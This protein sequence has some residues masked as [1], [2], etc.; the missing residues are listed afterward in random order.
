MQ[1]KFHNKIS[2]NMAMLPGP[3]LNHKITTAV[4][5]NRFDKFLLIFDIEK[6][7]LNIKLYECDQNRLCFLWFRNILKGDFTI[8]GYKNLRL[9][10]GLRPSPAILMLGLYKILILD[11]SGEE[12]LDNMKKAIYNGIYMDNGSYSCNKEEDLMEAFQ[13]LDGIFGPHKLA[14]QQFGTN[15]VELQRVVDERFEETTPSSVKFFGMMWNRTEDTLSPQ[16]INLQLKAMTKRTILSTLNSIYD[17]YNVYAPILLR[18]K[19][20]M[21]ILQTRTDLGWDTVIPDELQEEWKRIV[22]QAN[23]SP[24]I[25]LPR[26][27]GARGSKYSLVAFTDASKDAYGVVV[28]IK[29]MYSGVVSYLTAKN[30]IVNSGSL[31]RTIP[32]LELQGVCFGAETLRELKDSL[33][34]TSVVSP[35]EISSLVL[36]SDSTVCLHWLRS[37]SVFFEKMQKVTIFVKNRLRDIDNVCN[38]YPITFHHIGGDDN[39]ADRLTRPSSYKI[40]SRTNYFVGP[41]LLRNDLDVV[42]NDLSFILPNATC[43]KADEVPDH[44]GCVAMPVS[45]S[46]DETQGEVPQP[47]QLV[48]LDKYSS[49]KFLVGVTANIIKFVNNIRKK[50]SIKRNTSLRLL[51]NEEIHYSAV[52]RIISIEQQRIYKDIFAYLDS[53]SGSQ[54]KIPSL[55]NKY[56]VFQDDYKVLRV[57][58]KMSTNESSKLILLPKDSLVTQLLIQETHWGMSHAGIYSVIRELR[59][60]FWIE[61]FFSAVKIALKSCIACRKMNERPIR[62]NQSSYREFRSDPPMKPFRSVFLDY[63]GPF[64]VK[65]EGKNTRV[66]LLAITCL[67][68]RAVNLIVCRKANVDDFLRGIQ[69]HCFEYGIFQDCISDMGSQI[70]AGANIIRTFLSDYQTKS[71]LSLNG[72]KEVGFQHYAKGNSALGSVIESMVKQVKL[73]IFKSIKLVILDYFQFEYIIRKTVSLINK[74]PIAFKDGLRSVPPGELPTVVTPELLLKGYEPVSINVI[75]DLQ[76]IEDEDDSGWDDTTVIKSEFDK[77]RKVRENLVDYY[78][79]DFIYNLIHQAVDKGDRYKTVLHKKLS[80]G[81]IV[82][83]VEKYQKRYCYPMG[84]I[85]TVETNALGE[86]TAARVYKGD[87]RETVY[88]HATSL[89]RL[90][91]DE[92]NASVSQEKELTEISSDSGK[93]RQPSA[94]LA[95]VGCRKKIRALANNH[96][97]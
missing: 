31:K 8:V 51:Q 92:D 19:L 29:D 81:D 45:S 13:M 12:K 82:L 24:I 47:T 70:M 14:L 53:S 56:N 4:L 90:I 27:V 61:K 97:I 52:C 72:I 84:R 40:L 94:R 59:K 18:A 44:I 57:K 69:L 23:A 33:S 37:Y 21:Q 58:S 79:S 71:F 25:Q 74:R 93:S 28:Y 91:H 6:A 54:I 36:F 39:P 46:V 11:Q 64:T 96:C 7:F 87:T 30:R 88:R 2:H 66:L 32:A 22:N 10:F 63:I 68:S 83:L 77:L 75:P 42:D 41:P 73:L 78:H 15:S 48:P 20:F 50:I 67:W 65:L 95:A 3:N 60:K 38:K 26:C 85:V 35:I 49:W 43:K 9:S 86:T 80:V 34:G 5:M 17:I 55:M 1:Q 16:K 89:I 76:P 62:L